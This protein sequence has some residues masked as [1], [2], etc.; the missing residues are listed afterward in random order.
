[1]GRLDE[2]DLSLKLSEEEEAERLDAGWKRLTGLR[3]ALG[4]KLPGYALG[5]PV[6][7][8]FEGWDASGKGGAIKRLVAPLDMRHVRVG[9]FAAPSPDE[10]RHHYLWRFWPKL[11]G[12]G[13]MAVFDRSW[14]GRVLAERVEGY[15]TPEQWHRA[16]GEI[17]ELERTL[18]AEG[19]VLIKFFLHIS[20]EEQLRRFEQRRDDPL[21]TWKLTPADWENRRKRPQYMEAIEDMLART[22]HDP[23]P[24]H[25][26]E[27]ESKKYARVKVVE[28]VIERIERGMREQQI[29]PPAFGT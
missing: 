26:V 23:S 24:W 13:G 29:E 1:M 8:L 16:Y 21:K 10:A 28:T 17:V 18:D 6:C 4:A 25:L 5:P 11:P 15:A 27:A 2:L 7:V 3:L 12:W 14:Y 9:Q 19:M 20:E 22:D